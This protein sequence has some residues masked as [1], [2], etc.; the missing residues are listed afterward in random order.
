MNQSILTSIK[1]LLNIDESYVAFDLDILI[2]INS[3]LSTLNQ[4]GIGPTEGLI[5]EDA[6]VTWGTFLGT[7]A[8]LYAVKAYVYLRSRLLFD[9]PATSFHLQAIEKQIT[10]FEWR[11]NVVREGDSWVP[12]V[13]P[14]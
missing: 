4:L 13:E 8:R 2:Y 10:E 12:P 1:K 3:A 14:V 6:A 9:P 5:V 11:L 7:D